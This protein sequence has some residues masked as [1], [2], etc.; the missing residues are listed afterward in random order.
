MLVVVA[1]VARTEGE[2]ELSK[3]ADKKSSWT[4][5]LSNAALA[6]TASSCNP[7][8]QLP[9]PASHVLPCSS[10]T[11]VSHWQ[12]ICQIPLQRLVCIKD[13]LSIITT[14]NGFTPLSLVINVCNLD[15]WLK[16]CSGK[17]QYYGGHYCHNKGSPGVESLAN[18]DEYVLCCLD[19]YKG[20]A[21]ELHQS[22]MPFHS[23]E[24]VCLS[25]TQTSSDTSR[26]L[27]PN[28]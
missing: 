23:L 21:V 13:K 24:A 16:P 27:E 26:K 12:R 15:L 25:A 17:G 5:Q 9:L 22:S 6:A 19:E 20:I 3:D 28:S 1:V 2:T 18:I 14:S 8:Q 10:N 4:S 7:R 11:S